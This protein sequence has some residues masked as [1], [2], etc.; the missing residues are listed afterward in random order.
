MSDESLKSF[1][2][3]P[4]LKKLQIIYS[5]KFEG[6]IASYLSKYF[7]NLQVLN[8]ADCPI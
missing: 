6:L 4:N 7:Y 8:L 3:C 5:R 2:Y 1:A